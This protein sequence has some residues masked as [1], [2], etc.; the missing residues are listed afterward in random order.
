MSSMGFVSIQDIE[1]LCEFS[2]TERMNM[3]YAVELSELSPSTI[4]TFGKFTEVIVQN[5]FVIAGIVS[6]FIMVLSGFTI[7]LSS[8]N[9]SRQKK[10]K[11]RLR[12][13]SLDCLSSLRHF[14][15]FNL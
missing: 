2:Y 4:T 3:V 5:M 8:G 6:L 7:V 10:E 12:V 15:L 9:P 1:I 11:Q 14:G 13:L